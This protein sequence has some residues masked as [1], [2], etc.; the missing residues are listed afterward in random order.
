MPQQ[1]RASPLNAGHP[2]VQLRLPSREMTD[3]AALAAQEQLRRVEEDNRRVRETMV[4][5][6]R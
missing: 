3:A 1:R 6:W 4:S 5:E 2:A